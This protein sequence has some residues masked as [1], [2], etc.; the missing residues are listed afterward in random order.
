MNDL[1]KNTIY[2]A[3]VIDLWSTEEMDEGRMICRIDLDS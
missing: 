2:Q 1:I 3:K